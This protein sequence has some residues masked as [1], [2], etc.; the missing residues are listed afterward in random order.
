MHDFEGFVIHP[1]EVTLDTSF[2]VNALIPS[3]PLHASSS[4]FMNAL[5]DAETVLVY[6]RLVELEL[7]ETAFKIAV[8]EQHGNRAWPRMRNDGRVR[9]R[10]GRLTKD[11]LQAWTDL[12]SAAPHLCIEL[13]EV[14]ADVPDIM[15]DT[16]LASMDAAHAATATYAGNGAM[17]T[18]D[19]GFGAVPEANLELYVDAGR[20]RSVR[21]RRGGAV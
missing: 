3:E 12:L 21:R 19:A 4:A 16:G 18:C 15:A 13:H 8:R 5:V 10:A 6:N 7:A 11:L 1:Q 20:V 9:R 2:I 14:S 17:V